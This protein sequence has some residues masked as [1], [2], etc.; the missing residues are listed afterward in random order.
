VALNFDAKGATGP[1]GPL[2]PA[3]APGPKGPAGLPGSDGQPG[4]DGQPGLDG[5][6]GKNAVSLFVAA[7]ADGTIE[8]QSGG[9]SVDVN[10]AGVFLVNFPHQVSDCVPTA[11]IN[12]SSGNA[13]V[14]AFV[15]ARVSPQNPGAADEVEV[16]TWS[17]GTNL[18]RTSFAF[19][20][21]VSCPVS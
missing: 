5:T 16:D 14:P 2:G 20:L 15:L 12:D 7:K 11:T 3:G 10:A 9:V 6:P 13:T 19:N 18:P 1:I 4:R 21:A 8:N 17:T